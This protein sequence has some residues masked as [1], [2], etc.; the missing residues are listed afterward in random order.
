[1]RHSKNKQ[2]NKQTEYIVISVQGNI[3][4]TRNQFY[5]RIKASHDKTE[6]TFWQDMI[7]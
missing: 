4:K 2:T 5:K 3:S 6:A 7:F 1:M